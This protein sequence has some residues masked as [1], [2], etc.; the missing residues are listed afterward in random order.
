MRRMRLSQV[1]REGTADNQRR[2]PAH[3][4]RSSNHPPHRRNIHETQT[5]CPHSTAYLP[6]GRFHAFLWFSRRDRGD[7]HAH[8]HA[9]LDTNTH[10][11]T[12]SHSH[13]HPHTIGHPYP[14]V[15]PESH[16]GRSPESGKADGDPRAASSAGVRSL[17]PAAALNRLHSRHLDRQSRGD[18]LSHG[19]LRLDAKR[20]PQQAELR[21]T[22][23][24]RCHHGSDRKSSARLRPAG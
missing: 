8:C 15:N 21:S 11:A 13:H 10:S 22:G 12:N 7:T 20:H 4:R 2:L 9:H 6:R 19:L 24:S 5:N 1:A 23:S 14:H 3:E 17:L 18:R 16:T